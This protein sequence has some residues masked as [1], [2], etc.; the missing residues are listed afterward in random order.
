M[1]ETYRGNEEGPRSN[2]QKQGGN[3][4]GSRG[5]W[6]KH[7]GGNEGRSGGLWMKHKGE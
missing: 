4:G 6:M 3:E 1:D 7:N 5:Q 2:G